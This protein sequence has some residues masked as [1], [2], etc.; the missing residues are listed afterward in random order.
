VPPERAWAPAE[1]R[2]NQKTA[3]AF[4]AQWNEFG[5]EAA[6]STS[7]LLLHLP[8]GWDESVLRGRV[9]DVGCGMGRY[10][11]LVSAYAADVVGMDVSRA[12]SK[13]SE[14][15]PNCSFVQA[16]IVSPPFPSESFDLVYSFGVLHHLPDPVRGFRR[17]YDLVRPGGRLLVW[18]YSAH[19]GI[20]RRA[21]RVARSAALRI[22]WL[23]RPVAY[24]AASLIYLVYVVPRRMTGRGS[25][26]MTY[27][28]SKRFRHLFIDCY[29]ALTAPAEIYLSE[30][31]CRRWVAALG[32]RRSGFERRR[33]GSGWILWAQK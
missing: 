20:L 33:D 16:D 4:G 14:L 6:V 30:D 26:R 2:L 11:A 12:A 19:G 3:S 31:D 27:Y 13:A 15:W 25:R 9:L 10:A 24:A 1:A 32:A 5:R 22:P 28:D 7:D 17:C 21:R 23:R 18:V 8:T 29:D